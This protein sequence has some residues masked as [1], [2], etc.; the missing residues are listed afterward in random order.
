[1]LGYA[2]LSEDQIRAGIDRLEEALKSSGTA[3]TGV[4]LA[5]APLAPT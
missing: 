5:R 3:R 2:S 4:D 1:L